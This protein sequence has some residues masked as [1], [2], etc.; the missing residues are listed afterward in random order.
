MVQKIQQITILKNMYCKN[1]QSKKFKK[2]NKLQSLRT[3]SVE[4]LLRLLFKKY[5]KLQSLRTRYQIEAP[6][7]KF[8]KYN[9]LQSLRTTFPRHG[10]FQRSK[11]TTNY[12]P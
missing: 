1:H 5:N 10:I 6:S 4:S 7:V 3:H 12:N 11:N 9:K 2:Y 8:K